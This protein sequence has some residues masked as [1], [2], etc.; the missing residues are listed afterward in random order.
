MVS[1]NLNQVFSPDPFSQTVIWPSFTN[2]QSAQPAP[3][4]FLG[5]SDYLSASTTLHQVIINYFAIY[6]YDSL[7]R[8][9][10]YL[11]IQQHTQTSTRL[12]ALPNNDLKQRY[13]V[14]GGDNS[15]TPLLGVNKGSN[16]R[17]LQSSHGNTII[18]IEDN[19]NSLKNLSEHLEPA[20]N[21]TL[22]P[23]LNTTTDLLNANVSNI[24]GQ[25]FMMP[26]TPILTPAP[27]L[28]DMT[29]KS[30]LASVSQQQRQFQMNL[31]SSL[32]I[33]AGLCQMDR[34]GSV[35]LPTDLSS[36]IYSQPRMTAT[37]QNE[38]PQQLTAA[39]T[40]PSLTTLDSSA[41][42]FGVH[43]SLF[44]TPDTVIA[45]RSTGGLL[46]PPSPMPSKMAPLNPSLMADN[47][48]GHQA[49]PPPLMAASP[50]SLIAVCPI[51][52]EAGPGE[53][54]V[55][56]SRRRSKSS[57]VK[58]AYRSVDATMQTDTPVC[59]DED[60]QDTNCSCNKEYEKECL[61]ECSREEKE[62]SE[63]MSSET[64]SDLRPSLMEIT[65][66]SEKTGEPVDLSG[67]KLLSNSIEEFEKKIII[68]KEML[69]NRANI[70][71]DEE[72][73][74]VNR[75]EEEKSVEK[76]AVLQSGSGNESI[77]PSAPLQ[78]D[79][80][81][82][83]C[84]LAEQ[85]LVEEGNEVK[86]DPPNGVSS[87]SKEEF[88]SLEQSLSLEQGRSTKRPE[89]TTNC[90]SS[91]VDNLS[92]LELNIKKR[93]ADLTRQCEE[94]RRELDKMDQRNPFYRMGTYSQSYTTPSKYAMSD[95]EE[96]QS[97]RSA[98][99]RTP[100]TPTLLF[101]SNN[102]N[103]SAF[104]SDVPKI[105]SD[106]ESSKYDE[107]DAISLE[108]MSKRKGVVP[109]KWDDCSETET[110]VAKKPKSLV[111]YIFSLKNRTEK[112]IK[113]STLIKHGQLQSVQYSNSLSSGSTS[114]ETAKSE[115]M[116]V[117]EEIMDGG[118]DEISQDA[119]GS[120]NNPFSFIT[121]RFTATTSAELGEIPAVDLFKSKCKND[122]MV[123]E[124]KHHK[125][126]KNKKHRHKFSTAKKKRNDGMS[127]RCRLTQGH[128]DDKEIKTRVLT[129]MGGL[130]Y[131]GVLSP[132]QPPD[133]YSVILD[134]QRGNRPHI[135]SREE[136]QRDAILEIVPNDPSEVPPGTR[137]CAY[138]SQQYRCLYPGTA[139][140]PGTPDAN[141]KKQYIS[142][143]FDDGDSGRIAIN[144]IRLLFKDYPIVGKFVIA[145][146]CLSI[147]SDCF[148][149]KV[150]NNSVTIFRPSWIC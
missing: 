124:R 144:D 8:V 64:G 21:F 110:I 36:V 111:G 50:S 68:K 62:R 7:T 55:V 93:L 87:S 26:H 89:S 119:D 15:T 76:D 47:S 52:L 59:S 56:G 49:R 128:L 138:W 18:K 140:Q 94:K 97:S 135:M 85:R 143:E 82:L 75:I 19:T 5:P 117:K 32:Q 65:V 48:S 132:I 104:V 58:I 118:G 100:L 70:M 72:F 73:E 107:G 92:D 35:G 31:N 86:A 66:E 126:N 42:T 39:T 99:V 11:N 63:G 105:S 133:I 101:G 84:A 103:C 146:R 125:K 28:F 27:S 139:A 131:A 25:G 54:E 67:L 40:L 137:L 112:N 16:S 96:T 20:P 115:P 10:L 129:S 109:R 123:E 33:D 130:F 78:F 37:T 98:T 17:I 44:L 79:G 149:A 23:S 69:G 13:S 57:P 2:V 136:V 41:L 24:M 127:H 51:D 30:F 116:K 53:A 142:V 22:G 141:S 83:L 38:F 4:Q 74:A 88:P 90:S 1:D 106:T 29:D 134:G 46:T 81:N 108:R 3:I 121:N 150:I 102:A 71:K 60:T 9:A 113:G 122:V 147:H 77:L 145:R 12:V 114:S 91:N 43:S 61:G 80:L 120:E 45:A 34:G 95:D 148:L 14:T 6:L